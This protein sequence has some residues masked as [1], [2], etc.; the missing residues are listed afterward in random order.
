MK[1][2]WHKKKGSFAVKC[3]VV[4]LR[5]TYVSNIAEAPP[6][7]HYKESNMTYLGRTYQ[8]ENSLF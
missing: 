3:H 1:V 2:D 4:S 8:Y 6:R 5:R 7:N